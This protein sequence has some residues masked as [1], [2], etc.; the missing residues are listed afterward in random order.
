[1]SFTV[2]TAG[3]PVLSSIAMANWRHVNYGSPLIPVTTTG[4]GV[5]NTIDLGSSSYTFKHFYLSGT[6]DLGTNTIADGV[7]TGSWNFDSN[8]L[9]VDSANNRV[10]IGTTSPLSNLHINSSSTTTLTIDSGGTTYASIISF[11][12]DSERAKITGA[13]QTSGGGGYLAFNTDSSGGS[14]VERMRI[15]AD[16]NVGIGTSSPDE[17]LHLSGTDQTYIRIESTRTGGS[18]EDLGGILFEGNDSTASANGIRASIL[19]T[20]EGTAGATILSFSTAS[21][22]G[23][24]T[25]RMRITSTGN[26]GIGTSS[27]S[28]KLH[29]SESN[30]APT[31][32]QLLI[33]NTA[34]TDSDADAYIEFQHGA[35]GKAV[36]IVADRAANYSGG[37]NNDCDLVFHTAADDV[38]SEKFRV[39]SSGNVG[40]GTSSPTTLLHLNNDT[41]GA[42]TA[43]TLTAENDAGTEKNVILQLDPDTD[44]FS[45]DKS[46]RFAGKIITGTETAP[47]CDATGLCVTSS[48]EKI[49]I[50]FKDASVSHG[51]TLVMEDDTFGAIGS[52]D[53]T[54]SPGYGGLNIQGVS[55]LGFNGVR[56]FGVVTGTPDSNSDSSALGAVTLTG[57]RKSGTSTTQLT[58]N[59]NVVVIGDGSLTTH[60]FKGDGDIYIDGTTTAYDSEDDIMLVETIR[61]TWQ[62]IPSLDKYKKRLIKLG[63]MSEGGFMSTK[64]MHSLELGAIGQLY[65]IIK[66]MGDKLGFTPKEL[67]E[68]SKEY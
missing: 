18:T 49:A 6:I 39:T 22:S 46:T 35:A 62:D 27:P 44:L 36:K 8:T 52:Y 31:Q 25:E 37:A 40:I 3:D 13:Y 10:G 19:A 67:L 60:I 32:A 55:N 1:M 63:I 65:N 29:I 45:I 7:F 34:T 12:A 54:T 57:R 21:N 42:N 48:V 2:I 15:D 50:T 41:H 64:K 4:A 16:G 61:N 47:D 66:K 24:N 58:A 17:K 26:V 68:F 53:T 30:G 14:D 20:Y 51:V 23:S 38:Y 9:Y 11:I 59:Q 43:I 28:A 56:V 33:S 5:D